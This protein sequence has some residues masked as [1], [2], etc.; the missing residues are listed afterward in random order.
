MDPGFQPF[1]MVLWQLFNGIWDLFPVLVY[2]IKWLFWMR[3]KYC[4]WSR[5]Y[6][7]LQG[8]CSSAKPWNASHLWNCDS[9]VSSLLEDIRAPF[10]P[11]LVEK[12]VWI[13]VS[14][15]SVSSVTLASAVGDACL[16]CSQLYLVQFGLSPWISLSEAFVHPFSPLDCTWA[17][18]VSTMKW[19]CHL[20]IDKG[21]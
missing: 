20:A 10:T 2:F 4:F 17:T 1:L 11:F 19:Q 12:M 14:T 21:W 9:M 8:G 16:L 5:H 13:F 15:S 3:N 7:W 18:L 6:C